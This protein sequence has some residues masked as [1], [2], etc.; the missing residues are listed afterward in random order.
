MFAVTLATRNHSG[1]PLFGER[2]AARQHGGFRPPGGRCPPPDEA[3]AAGSM[4][5]AAVW[6]LESNIRAKP[7]KTRG[8]ENR[9]KRLSDFS[10]CR[11]AVGKE[12][13]ILL[14]HCFY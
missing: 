7:V 12:V 2:R 8:Y 10:Q 14:S 11:A 4:G 6:P 1:G 3:A 9:G 13:C 5:V